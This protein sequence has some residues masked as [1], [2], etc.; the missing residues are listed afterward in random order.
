MIVTFFVSSLGKIMLA[1]ASLA[2]LLWAHISITGL[3][4]NWSSLVCMVIFKLMCDCTGYFAAI[5]GHQ[6]VLYL[7]QYI[8]GWS[9]TILVIFDPYNDS[10]INRAVV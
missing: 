3:C 4:C 6:A 9:A 2:S 1:F 10:H 7:L 8:W 5:L